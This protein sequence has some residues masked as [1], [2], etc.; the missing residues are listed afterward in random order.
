[1]WTVVVRSNLLNER[2]MTAEDSHNDIRRSVPEVWT[3][4]M[5]I[6]P[7]EELKKQQ[8]PLT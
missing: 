7:L 6:I 2:K 8:V 5:G 3:A 1:M 4:D